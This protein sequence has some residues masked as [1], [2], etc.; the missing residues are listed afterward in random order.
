MYSITRC[1]NDKLKK[2]GTR[3][4]SIT[5]QL[6]DTSEKWVRTMCQMSLPSENS[7]VIDWCFGGLVDSALSLTRNKRRTLIILCFIY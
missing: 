2:K 6:R 1:A 7:V 4:W 5:S 3:V